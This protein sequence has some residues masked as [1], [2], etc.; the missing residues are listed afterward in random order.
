MKLRYVLLLLCFLTN[1][2]AYG[3]QP[4]LNK[5]QTRQV[6]CL[7]TAIYHEA[8]GEPVEGQIAVA[9][10]V[11]NRLATEKYPNTV[12]GVVYDPHQFTDIQ[13]AR[14]LKSSMEWSRAKYI[15]SLAYAKRLHDVTKG[16][17]WYYGHLVIPKPWWA[18]DKRVT[19][20]VGGHT[21]LRS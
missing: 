16:A 1:N 5:D 14:P 17:L 10:V 21:F 20:V 12:C 8:R 19:L 11:M 7:A 4:Q 6:N 18:K 13:K 2:A 3:Q 9:N 15:A